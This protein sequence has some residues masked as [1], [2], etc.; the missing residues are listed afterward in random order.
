MHHS[1]Q[2]QNVIPGTVVDQTITHPFEYD[3]YL[4]SH[5]GIQV[6]LIRATSPISMMLRRARAAQGTS[7]P[8]HYYVLW[9][10][11][12]MGSDTVQM[13]SNV[14]CYT[15]ARCTRAVSLPAPVYYAHHVCTQ[16]K[17]RLVGHQIV[18]R[19]GSTPASIF[20][21]GMTVMRVL[22]TGRRAHS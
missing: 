22:Q 3:F 15:Y 11:A 1:L 19:G 12:K 9:D 6:L 14:L 8:T 5:Q 21:E 16:A 17:H 13:L 20:I 4:C 7:R 2:V 10:D 18:C